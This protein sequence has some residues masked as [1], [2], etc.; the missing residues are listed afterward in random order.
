MQEQRDIKFAP[1]NN[2]GERNYNL[3]DG[4]YYCEECGEQNA[5]KAEMEYDHIQYETLGQRTRKLLNKKQKP[6]GNL[7][8]VSSF[9]LISH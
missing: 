3:I 1:C 8:K 9:M 4:F 5:A 6:K 7:K 2:C